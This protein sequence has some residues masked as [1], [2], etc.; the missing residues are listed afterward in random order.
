M[1]DTLTLMIV[2]LCVLVILV[3]LNNVRADSMNL[4]QH[5]YDQ[6]IMEI[7]QGHKDAGCRILQDAL[8]SSKDLD[9]NFETYYQI[10]SIGTKICNWVDHPRSVETSVPKQ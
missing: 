10:W 3:C 8:S 9:D 6:A 1:R 7:E 4:T 2:C 5:L